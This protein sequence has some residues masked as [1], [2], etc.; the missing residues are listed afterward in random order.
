MVLEEMDGRY[1][2]QKD[3][4]VPKSVED[5]DLEW[6]EAIIDSQEGT[7]WYLWLLHL[8]LR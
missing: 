5:H 8:P 1:S 6:K 3:K 7:P 2:G 4:G